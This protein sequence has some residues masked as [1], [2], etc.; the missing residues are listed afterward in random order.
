MSANYCVFVYDRCGEHGYASFGDDFDA[1]IAR[2]V[3][4]TAH[5]KGLVVQACN[6]DCV[7]LGWPDGFTED[8]RER[9]EQALSAQS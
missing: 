2:A 5:Y 1:A 8:E 7:D 9:L 4:W 3:E 6:L